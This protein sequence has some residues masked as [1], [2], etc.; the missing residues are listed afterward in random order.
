[1]SGTATL[2][3]SIASSAALLVAFA[4]LMI[5]V[6]HRTL[7]RRDLAVRIMGGVGLFALLLLSVA[8][9][10]VAWNGPAAQPL[11]QAALIFLTIFALA[12]AALGVVR[13]MRGGRTVV[14][15]SGATSH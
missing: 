15:R 8:T 11:L 3:T 10:F 6:R 1:M 12:G 7:S 2:A 9:A 14:G 5:A 13:G 4:N